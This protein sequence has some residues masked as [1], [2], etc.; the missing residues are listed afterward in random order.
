MHEAQSK[1]AA[2]LPGRLGDSI[3]IGQLEALAGIES[4]RQ[5]R[6]EF[7]I[8]Y[9]ASANPIQDGVAEL[10]GMVMARLLAGEIC[11]VPA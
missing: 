11:A 8:R 3:T 2:K 7:W 9:R 1:T 6:F 5:S 4:D 10:R